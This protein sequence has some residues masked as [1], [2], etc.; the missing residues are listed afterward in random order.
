[1]QE[2]GKFFPLLG[3]GLWIFAAGLRM[4]DKGLLSLV[5]PCSASAKA[6]SE[7]LLPIPGISWTLSSSLGLLASLHHGGMRKV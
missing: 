6:V 3:K 2:S 1:M 7:S 5:S 4:Q